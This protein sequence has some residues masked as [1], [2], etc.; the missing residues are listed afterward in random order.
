MANNT[1]LPIPAFHFRVSW[2]G[3]FIGFQ[4][5]SGI[6]S[7]VIDVQEYRE[8]DSPDYFVSKIPGM[9]KTSGD[10]TMKRGLYRNNDELYEWFKL[11]NL[12]QPDRRTITVELL[13][14]THSTVRTWE[15]YN[16]WISKW[17]GPSL[18]SSSSDLATNSV[19]VTYENFEMLDV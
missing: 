4:E 5:A 18:N 14:E 6:A 16:C 12:D 8:G 15:F 9:K 13:D 17:E 7:M 3:S 10:L 11:T 1:D 19:T 2:G